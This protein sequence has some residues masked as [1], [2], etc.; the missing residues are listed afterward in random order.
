MVSSFYPN[1]GGIERAVQF[2]AEE[3]VSLGHDVHVI[4]SDLSRSGKRL[5]RREALG[6]MLIERLPSKLIF[7]GLK[8][9]IVRPKLKD[10]DVLHIHSQG[11]LFSLSIGMMNKKTEKIPCVLHVMAIDTLRDHPSNFVRSIGPLY[12][13]VG[14]KTALFF[15]DVVLARSR[16]DLNLLE[17]Q[18]G[19]KGFLVPDGVPEYY[20]DKANPG[21][22]RKKYQISEDNIILFIGRLNSLKGPHILLKSAPVVLKDFPSTSFVFIGP[23]DGMGSYLKREAERLRV[24]DRVKFL[25]FIEEV[26]K[27]SALEACSALAL[28][29]LSD[30]VEVYP[31]VVSEAWARKKPVIASTIGGIPWRVKHKTN[32]ILVP[33]NDVTALAKAVVQVLSRSDLARHWGNNGFKE[34][35]TWREIALRMHK[36]YYKIA[37]DLPKK[38]KNPAE[39]RKP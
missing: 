35:Y 6:R 38:D 32:G 27:L 12:E 3:L 39:R 14:L 17:T 15:A 19:I 20:F 31:M 26:D 30:I 25:G 21:R 34:V 8:V 37:Y 1:I 36:I 7:K 9:P 28:P 11:A 22:F 5:K 24:A 16:R 18:Y 4:T 33:P 10:Y 13:K 29:S 2:L 23:D